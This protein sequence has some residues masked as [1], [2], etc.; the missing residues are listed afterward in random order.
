MSAFSSDLEIESESV[1]VMCGG[2]GTMA[3][4]DR[5]LKDGEPAVPNHAL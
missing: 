4:S 5:E 2:V 3:C 1:D